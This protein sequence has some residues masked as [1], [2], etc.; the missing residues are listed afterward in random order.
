MAIITREK[1]QQLMEQAAKAYGEAIQLLEMMDKTI[2]DMAFK[3]DP[4]NRYDTRITLARFDTILQMILLQ[5]AV[6]DG[7]FSLKEGQFIQQI[8]KY[9][10]LL[11]YLRRSSQGKQDL[12]WDKLAKM[13]ASRLTMLVQLLPPSLERLCDSFVKP[14]AILDGAVKD[15][16]LLRMLCGH[17]ATICACMSYLDGNSSKQEANAY[18]DIGYRLLEGRWKQ[19]MK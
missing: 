3:N 10:D 11:D 2:Q 13:N 16:D 18:Y 4:E 15:M 5:M 9:G 8:V 12:T 17:I 19:Y 6:S 7:R 14:L 1:E